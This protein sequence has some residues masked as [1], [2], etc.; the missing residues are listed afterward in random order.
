LS[1]GLA[2]LFITVAEGWS[3]M[4]RMRRLLSRGEW[5][6][7]DEPEEP[8]LF[9]AALFLFM[10]CFALALPLLDLYE[11]E[12]VFDDLVPPALVPMF[13]AWAALYALPTHRGRTMLWLRVAHALS[14]VGGLALIVYS[15]AVEAGE[16]WEPVAFA[17]VT[18][19]LLFLV[20][21]FRYRRQR[22]R[23]YY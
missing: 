10:S 12:S 5:L 7:V 4:Y 14:L 19:L 18:V 11:G 16:V 2:N 23:R 1:K 21:L 22:G 15:V 8:D 13:F 17:A 6:L 20:L 9:L 3:A